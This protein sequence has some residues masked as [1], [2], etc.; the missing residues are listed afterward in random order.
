MNRKRFIQK[1]LRAL[2]LLPMTVVAVL[3]VLIPLGYVL[4][5]SF[6]SRDEIF[7]VTFQFTLSNYSR[8]LNPM[9]FRVLVDSLVLALST[10]ALTLLV[11]YPFGYY[12]ARLSVRTR[13]LVMLLLIAPFW[14]NAL[15]RLYGWRTFLQA[16]GPLNT[17]LQWLG[18]IDQPLKLLYNNG[19]VLL[20]MLYALLPFM[21]LPTYAAVEKMDWTL[22][23]AARDLGAGPVRAFF[24]VTLPR[25]LP[26]ILAGCVL[27]FVPS[28]GLFFISDLM[29]G[30]KTVLMGNLIR[31]QLLKARDWSFGAALS[32]MLLLATSLVLLVYRKISGSTDVGVYL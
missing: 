31:D 30:G 28:M 19:A 9:Y 1:L 7:G 21:I 25:T 27:V 32:V 20:G 4:V 17:F 3:F 26:G 2:L 8:I 5:L 18:V 22:V 16:N 12:M 6:L 11:G 13:A 23:E 14:T 15:V 10:T 29:G 24:T